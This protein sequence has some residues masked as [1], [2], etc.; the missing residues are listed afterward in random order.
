M[1]LGR[2][3]DL[4][5]EEHNGDGRTGIVFVLCVPEFYALT[6]GANGDSTKKQSHKRSPFPFQHRPWIPL[7][8][9]VAHVTDSVVMNACTNNAIGSINTG[10]DDDEGP[11]PR[12][13][14]H[15]TLG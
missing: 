11:G 13:R 9:R 6:R 14:F 2:D 5:V 10:E 3:S 7:H 15:F 8:C 12:V 1:D 4:T